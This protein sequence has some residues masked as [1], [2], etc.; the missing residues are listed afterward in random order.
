VKGENY[1]LLLVMKSGEKYRVYRRP[2][3][4]RM[5]DERTTQYA[6]KDELVRTIIANTGVSIDPKDVA[7]VEIIMQPNKKEE[8][9][10]NEKGPLYKK[11]IG[12]LD[13]ESVAARFELLALDEHFVRKFAKKYKGVR[14]LSSLAREIEGAI[15]AKE[16]YID[17]LM[18]LTEKVFSTYKGCR[19][20]YLTMRAYQQ[21]QEL[22]Q[23]RKALKKAKEFEETDATFITKEEMEEMRLQYLSEHER[24]LLDID[25]FEG[26]EELSPFDAHK[27][28]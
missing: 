25:D 19:N 24:E 28:K 15:I 27:S 8:A 22:R 4:L 13:E 1:Y 16:S 3:T 14:N 23:R 18:C 17:P 21:E 6:N 20:T 7:D 26:R 10:K 2:I 11:D 5:M 9:Y 12:V